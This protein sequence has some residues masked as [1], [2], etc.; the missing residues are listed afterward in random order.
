MATRGNKEA[1]QVPIH[2]VQKLSSAGS[3]GHGRLQGDTEV[4]P[5]FGLCQHAEASV[6]PSGEVYQV[7]S[8]FWMAQATCLAWSTAEHKL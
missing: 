2:S 6:P 4:N 7:W 3:Y 8:Y 1:L 5:C